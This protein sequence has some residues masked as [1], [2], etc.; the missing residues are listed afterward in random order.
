M[1]ELQIIHNLLNK[2]QYQKYRGYI[3]PSEEYEKYYKVLDKLSSLDRDITLEEYTAAL[4][5]KLEF[6][7]SSSFGEDYIEK[8]LSEIKLRQWA[9]DH[10]A[11]AIDV[12]EGRKDVSMLSSHLDIVS[13]TEIEQTNIVSSS[14]SE[15]VEQKSRNPSIR[16]RLE[17]LN[18]V[19]GGLEQGN[20]AFI[21][22]RPETGKT[23]F[24]AS[25]VTHFAKQVDRPILW[26]NNEEAGRKVMERLY[27]AAL[28]WDKQQLYH[29]VKATEERYKTV[30][31]D[32][33]M[34]LDSA[35]T[36]FWD[37]QNLCKKIKP[38]LIILDQ[39]DKI[40]GFK[41]DKRELELGMKYI[42]AREMAKT[43]CPV[44]GVSQASD[45]KENQQGGK[46][47]LTESDVAESKT[48]KAAE[49]DLIIGIGK[50]S[51][52]ENLRGLNIIKNKLTGKH[53]RITCRIKPDVAR[54]E[55]L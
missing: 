39:L 53:S 47:W 1:L 55:D 16:F 24:L 32:N 28:G 36:T 37:V 7:I 19:T 44:I 41:S 33:I 10:A 17:S 29:D 3:K 11:L 51:Q 31:K 40:K 45:S 54:Y 35:Q 25:E 34:I 46:M 13:S 22:A 38:S 5:D 18:K 49:G 2:E 15:L 52:S 27:C 42:W 26:V 43:Y 9:Y 14:L 21:F 48:S 50:T 8:A 30:T 6:N 23:T 12:S 20:F 4:P